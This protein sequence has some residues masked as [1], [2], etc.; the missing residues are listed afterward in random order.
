MDEGRRR[1]EE[2]HTIVTRK[3]QITIPAQ[4]RRAL[5]LRQGDCV[6]L[7]L[8][9]G[10]ARLAKSAS[11]VQ[12]TAGA[13]KGRGPRL[14]AEQLRRAAETAA[15]DEAVERSTPVQRKRRSSG[16]SVP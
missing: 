11:V 1:V 13:F 6:A 8:E 2:L 12:R 16:S 14:T 10:R 15:A 3:G 7:T 9:N 4:I 5:G